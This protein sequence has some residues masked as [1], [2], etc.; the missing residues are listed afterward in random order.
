MK[1][2]LSNLQKLRILSMI[3]ISTFMG[4]GKING[5]NTN[6]P[7]V[8]LS[9]VNAYNTNGHA[10]P[11]PIVKD[12]FLG[13]GL[14]YKFFCN[15]DISTPDLKVKWND[16]DAFIN[17]KEYENNKDTGYGLFYILDYDAANNLYLT[18]A[19][20]PAYFNDNADSV[21]AIKGSDSVL[22]FLVIE[23]AG[24]TRVIDSS[25]FIELRDLY[26]DSLDVCGLISR[27]IIPIKS[28]EKAPKSCY[29]SGKEVHYFF[30][31]NNYFRSANQIKD[32]LYV[33]IYNGGINREMP[34][35]PDVPFF[36]DLLLQTPILMFEYG[37]N[38]N[39]TYETSRK[40]GYYGK[41][42]EVGRLCPPECD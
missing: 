32:S 27:S 4:Y 36:T 34:P 33:R 11:Y 29:Y 35:D 10:I 41:A 24:T 16:I 20:S 3:L 12:L 17:V 1:T 5:Q 9:V 38:P 13:F 26:N 2:N 28:I 18:Y 40:Y 7:P 6:N 31:D 21:F 30:D 19:I 22:N 37:N 8:N 25:E 39:I 23:A 14:S 15:N 42:L